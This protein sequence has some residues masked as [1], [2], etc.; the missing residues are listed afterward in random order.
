MFCTGAAP[1]VPGISA[2]FSSPGQPLRQR[3]GHE[4]VP[5]LAGA[6]L[7]DPGVGALLDAG[8]CRHLDLQHDLRHVARE[9]HVA[10]AA[11]HELGRERRARGGRRRGARR[12]RCAM[13]TSVLRHGRQAEACCR[14]CRLHAR[15]SIC[16]A[17]FSLDPRAPAP[18]AA[19]RC[20][21]NAQ[22][23]HRPRTRSRGAAQRRRPDHQGNRHALRLQGLSARSRA[24]RTRSSRSGPTATSSS[25]R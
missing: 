5:V 6:G 10:A 15:A 11:Q 18:S 7:D 20:F 12:R 1:T 9:D 3:P 22:L 24:A 13:R 25:A 19:A 21:D 4:L 8:A 17:E 14:A 2:R 23:R 16:M